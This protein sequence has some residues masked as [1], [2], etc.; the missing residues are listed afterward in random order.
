[1]SDE[2]QTTFIRL[3]TPEELKARPGGVRSSAYNFGFST[4]MGRL[5]ASH[6]RIGPA[7]QAFFYE[8]MI[9]PGALSRA[10]REM[11]AA[12]TSAAQDCQY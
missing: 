3:P 11:L 4:Q 8:V 12:V 7:M 6:E 10:E 1:M 5:A 2:E 9:A